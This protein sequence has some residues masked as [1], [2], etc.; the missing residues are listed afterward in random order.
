M[1]D[2][3]SSFVKDFLLPGLAL[4]GSVVAAYMSWSTA[5]DAHA[6]QVEI[7]KLEAQQA[8]DE[9]Q[10][11]VYIKTYEFVSSVVD[12]GDENSVEFARALIQMID[13]AEVEENLTGF[14]AEEA[15]AASKDDSRPADEREQLAKLATDARMDFE[16]LHAQKSVRLPE[17]VQAVEPDDP[18]PLRGWRIQILHCDS[19][20]DASLELARRAARTVSRELGAKAYLTK[21]AGNRAKSSVSDAP[22]NVNYT[23]SSAEEKRYGKQIARLLNAQ[24]LASARDGKQFTLRA[25]NS[26]IPNHMSVYI[27]L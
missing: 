7:T 24:A 21:D 5:Q 15:K 17:V 27:C 2:S 13:D 20:D 16:L 11:E 18:R 10:F 9:F 19:T 8:R 25:V 6:L 12:K 14:L 1:S 4:A 26:K 3:S 22:L 23:S